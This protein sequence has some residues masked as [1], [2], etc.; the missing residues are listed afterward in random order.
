MVSLRNLEDS[1]PRFGFVF[2]LFSLPAYVS[3][4]SLFPFYMIYRPLPD[5]AHSGCTAL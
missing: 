4:Y 3:Q 2:G 5:R 1:A